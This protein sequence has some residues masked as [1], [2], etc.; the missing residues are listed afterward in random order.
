MRENVLSQCPHTLFELVA[1]VFVT[2]E[3]VEACAART[4]Q[5]RFT[6]LCQTESGVYGIF[7]TGLHIGN[8]QSHTVEEV[9]QLFIVQPQVN[10]G[11]ALFAYQ[12]FNLRV[13]VAFVLS[14]QDK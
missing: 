3:E 2:L 9:V 4:Q 7:H 8:G 5:H 14:A 10:Q 13:V 1:A 11:G 6:F 12:I